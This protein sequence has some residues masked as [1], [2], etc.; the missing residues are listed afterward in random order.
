MKAKFLQDIQ[1]N[2]IENNRTMMIDA[3]EILSAEDRGDYYEL[4]KPDGWG[5]MAPKEC[6]GTIY[7]ILRE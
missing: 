4:R 6:E 2:D 3:G 1:V 7:E 5:T